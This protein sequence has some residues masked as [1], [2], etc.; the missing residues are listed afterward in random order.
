MEKLT[1]RK[2]LKKSLFSAIWYS[3]ESKFNHENQF[4]LDE[5]STLN[6]IKAALTYS[7]YF[8]KDVPEGRQAKVDC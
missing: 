7:A 3:R 4:P 1:K 2:F 6:T 8:S 5:N